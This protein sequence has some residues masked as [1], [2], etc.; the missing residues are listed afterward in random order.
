MNDL[1]KRIAELSPAKLELLAQRL[2][3]AGTDN[4]K[5]RITRRS[6]AGTAAP[7]TFAQQRLW[8]LAQLHPANT[9]YN[10][11]LAVRLTGPLDLA[12]LEQS[13]NEVLR[14]HEA[15]R[16]SFAAS[17]GKPIQ[18]IAPQLHFTLPVVDHTTVSEDL[19]A[20]AI[21]RRAVEQAQQPFDLREAP[22]LRMSLLRLAEDEHVV[23]FT[24]HHII[25][26]AWSLNLLI[27]E[28]AKL[29]EAFRCGN[30][31][32]LPSLP[33]Q[34]AD[35]AVWQREVLQG[36]L[37][38]AELNYWRQQLADA[39][40]V[41]DLPT[42]HPRLA[43]Q[44][45]RGAT[46]SFVLD[47]SLTE[48]LIQLSQRENVTLF[49]TLLAVFQT[50]LY[51]YTKQEDILVG[52]PIA[53]RNRIETEKLIGFFAD[54]LVLRTRISGDLT[55]RELLAHV[56][57]MALGTYSHQDLPFEKLVEALQPERDL[58]RNP[59]FQVLFALRNTPVQPLH[60]SGLVWTPLKLNIPKARFDLAL[61]LRETA[62]G[63]A[64]ACEYNAG[65]FEAATIDSFLSHY[66]T[67]LKSVVLDP[68]ERVSYL[69]LLPDSERRKMLL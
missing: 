52:T 8:F 10:M 49:M 11:N 19:Q 61:D 29:Y 47:Q 68:E 57:E 5:Q 60:Q 62:N 41:L 35:F 40:F 55:F 39:P 56:R 46:Q 42:A 26:D 33:I 4:S 25:S 1:G 64:G 30:S 51:R 66:Q 18:V 12:A 69:P 43:V 20:A 48:A 65:L 53:G 2:K 27:L 44:N 54:S 13:L 14:R 36:E 45:V 63:I 28:I 21:E 67:L 34:Y 59:I 15:L 32:P 37:L 58:G 3:T 24:I 9:A 23:L 38:Q 50:L 6:V 22:L 17:D 31:S 7:L 16:T